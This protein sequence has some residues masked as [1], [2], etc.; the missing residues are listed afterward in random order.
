MVSSTQIDEEA[1]HGTLNSTYIV[2]EGRAEY[3]YRYRIGEK[4]PIDGGLC[5]LHIWR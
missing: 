2:K 3:K 1:L 5:Y 4:G